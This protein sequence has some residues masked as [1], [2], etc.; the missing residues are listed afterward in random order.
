MTKSQTR[1]I[2]DWI[3][4]SLPSSNIFYEVKDILKRNNLNTV[5]EGALCPNCTE[6][7]S[8]KTATFL[9]MGNVCTRNCKY[10]N[11]NSGSP[12]ELDIEEPNRVA[13][14]TKELGLK[15][16]VITSVT[17]DDLPN[18]GASHF[19]ETVNKIKDQ[20]NATIEALIPDFKGSEE[21]LQKVMKTKIDVLNH[22]IECAKNIFKEMR[23]QGNYKQS[24]KLL[25]KA[26]EINNN[27][28]TKSGF[29]IG[30]GETIEEIK[31][32]INDLKKSNVD[33][34]TIGQYLRP[35]K[36]NPEVSKYYTPDEFK[37]LKE[38]ALSIGFKHVESGPLIRSSY[39][40][41]E[42]IKKN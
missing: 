22:N 32:T 16:I 13:N 19:A 35:S 6:C 23:P 12:T 7:F 5:C 2:P 20:C 10:C 9:I 28:L 30:L 41:I 34:I 25:K 40:A 31:E 37:E 11:I 39:N 4:T 38:Y 24:L 42:A 18:Y 8:K 27:I 21:S 36:N 15:H 29:M 3:K 26:K 17:R 1:R 14:A 33:I